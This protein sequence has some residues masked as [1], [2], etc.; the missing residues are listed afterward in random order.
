MVYGKEVGANGTRHLQGYVEW[1]GVKRWNTMKAL[2][3]RIH[4]EARKGSAKQASEYCKKGEQ[5]HDEWKLAGSSGANYGKNAMVFEKGTVSAQGKRSELEEIGEQVVAMRPLREIA[6]E[7]PATYIKYAKGIEK[8]HN[9]MLKPR[10]SSAAPYIEWRW[11]LAGVG[12]TRYC[13]EKHQTS[14][15][16]KDGTQ[17]WDGYDQ[18][19]AIIIDDFDGRW[20][21]RDLLR[22]LD[23]YE[24][25]GQYKGG[26]V[27]INSPYI[28]ITCEHAPSHFW[29]GNELAQ[30]T[31]RITKIEN[32]INPSAQVGA[33]G[34]VAQKVEAALNKA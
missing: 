13:V 22:L 6:Q 30:V 8:L 25:Q 18:Q 31:R 20:P 32:V 10:D 17:W 26:Y 19:E 4:W 33:L 23:R 15:F 12:K 5:S 1:T 29:S 27:Q 28:Y 21:F 7:N 2:N 14:H 16:I 9:Q 11:G 34:T 3:P 24:Y